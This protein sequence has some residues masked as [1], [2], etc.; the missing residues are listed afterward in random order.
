MNRTQAAS[1]VA[2]IIALAL[3]GTPAAAAEDAAQPGWREDF[4]TP[5]RG[6]LPAGWEVKRKFGTRAA[7]F[8]LRAAEG[9]EGTVLAMTSDRATASAIANPT[10]VDLK[11][12]PILRWRWRVLALPA[13][14]DGRQSATDDQAIGI[15]AGTGS[16]LSKRS[17]SYRWDTV[18]PRG[19]EGTCAYGAGTIRIKWFTLRNQDDGLGEWR[20]EE[21]NLAEDFKAAWGSI[22]ADIYVSVSC[23]SQYTG[24]R[25]EAE[26]DW[27]ELAPAPAPVEPSRLPTGGAPGTP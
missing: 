7:V 13:G 8:S 10:G 1:V 23:N 11:L 14:G 18:T 4:S 3:V 15:Y 17:I 27:I 19:A 22:P 2:A 25:A 12:T 9:A 16:A 20:I 5:G 24:S 21:R 26:L 6:G